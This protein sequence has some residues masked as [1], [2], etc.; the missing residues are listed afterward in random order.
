MIE[1][2]T[3]MALIGVVA[4]VYS[5]YLRPM[6]ARLDTAASHL[7]SQL[8]SARLKAMATTSSYR[9]APL[10]D[11]V[12]I[13]QWAPTCSASDWT[14]DRRLELELP[15]GVRLAST[16]WSV[17]FSSRGMTDVNASVTVTYPDY[18]TRQ[19]E[20]FLGG[21]TRVVVP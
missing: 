11:A 8:R 6:E 20:V 10:T 7:E 3:V 16:D 2:L 21:A 4:G 15:R 13:A 5:L 12:V 9:V 18:G 1:L 14:L 19:V 17:C